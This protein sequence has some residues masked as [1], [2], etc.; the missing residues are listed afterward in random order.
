MAYRIDHHGTV[1]LGEVKVPVPTSVSPEAQAYLAYNTWGD[2]PVPE[3]PI[4]MW[5]LREHTDVAFK[6]LNEQSQSMF[7]VSITETEIGGVRCHLIEPDNIPESNKGRMLIN[8][9]AG[10]FVMGSGSLVEAI[11]IAHLT[12][13]PVIAVD[14]RLAPEHPFPAAVVDVLAVYREVLRD[15]KAE[16]VAIFGSSAGGFLTAQTVAR[17]EKEGLPVPACVGIFSGAGDL[18]DLGDTWNIFTANGFFGPLNLPLNSEISEVKVYLNGADPK[19]P[20][21]SPRFGDLSAFP[22]ALLISGTRDQVLSGA[23]NFHRALRAADRP[24]DFLVFDAMPHSH[25]FVLHLPETRETLDAMVR[26]FKRHLL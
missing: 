15:H 19:D 6:A 7:P 24:A 12:Q 5:L 25:W 17:C 1:D 26:F 10:G 13:M 18:L 23:A 22:P 3:E 11:P 4:P 2:A 16:H 21:V 9:H 14:Y 20:L 8:L